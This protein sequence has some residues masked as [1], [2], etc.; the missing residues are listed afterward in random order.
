MLNH[1]GEQEPEPAHH[2]HTSVP[3]VQGAYNATGRVSQAN[4]YLS[5]PMYGIR[6]THANVVGGANGGAL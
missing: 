5:S 6:N 4:G 1:S 3:A 2:F